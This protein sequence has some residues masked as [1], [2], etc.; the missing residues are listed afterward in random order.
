MQELHP[1]EINKIGVSCPYPAWEVP[2]DVRLTVLPEHRCAYLPDRV[3]QSRAF[4]A[5]R[6]APEVYHAL[7]DA[8]FRRS[9]KL[10]YQPVCRGCRQCLPIRVPLATF[11]PS[12]SQRRSVRKNADL[13]V[14]KG[15]LEV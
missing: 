10:V 5:E 6:M 8:G 12:K 1:I 14:S 4:W 3:A 2:I 7:M 9:G 15:A 13:V 11:Q